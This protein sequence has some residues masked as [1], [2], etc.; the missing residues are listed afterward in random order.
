MIH[1]A[2]SEESPKKKALAMAKLICKKV[3][4]EDG[5]RAFR[6]CENKFAAQVFIES[7]PSDIAQ[8]LFLEVAMTAM[9]EEQIEE[10]E[11]K[12]ETKEG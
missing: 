4:L 11:G 8:Q 12:S 7:V 3:E 1:A 2:S 10:L 6:N 5:T 9:S